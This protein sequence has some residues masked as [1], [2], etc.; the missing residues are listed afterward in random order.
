MKLFRNRAFGWIVPILIGA[1]NVCRVYVSN[2]QSFLKR[3]KTW[4]P[5]LPAILTLICILILVLLWKAP[6]WQVNR[7]QGVTIEN[8]FDRENEARKTLAQILGGFA[9]LVGLYFAAN[10]FMLQTENLSAIRD[11]Q[12]T[13]RYAKAVEQLGAETTYTNGK[14]TIKLEVRLGAIYALERIA[15][16]SKRDHATVMEIL[17]A[18]VRENTSNKRKDNEE[19]AGDVQTQSPRADIQAIL[20]VL[21][22]RERKNDMRAHYLNLRESDLMGADLPDL[23]AMDLTRANLMN[24]KLLS[25]N[26]EDTYLWGANLTGALL[27]RANLMNAK[28]YGAILINAHL[29]NANLTGADLKESNLQKADLRK[30]ML[31]DADLRKA[32]LWGANLNGAY[33]RGANLSEAV[34]LQQEQIN[35]TLSDKDTKLPQNVHRPNF[36]DEPAR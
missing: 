8:R 12:I 1:G 30:A 14:K 35:E 3:Q 13:D 20:T 26:L 18:Y 19:E 36:W 21:C 10:N 31:G 16:D 29:Y 22:R 17:T 34:G 23:R 28:L 11:G 32:R 5:P 33:L 24:A 27:D 2:L 7:S 9:V 15:R 25:A 6:Q 4:R